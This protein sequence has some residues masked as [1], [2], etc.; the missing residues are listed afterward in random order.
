[1]VP[2]GIAMHARAGMLPKLCSPRVRTQHRWSTQSTLARYATLMRQA[3][4]MSSWLHRPLPKTT[5]LGVTYV[6]HRLRRTEMPS[7]VQSRQLERISML[8]SIYTFAHQKPPAHP[9]WH[10]KPF[11]RLTTIL[12]SPPS[13]LITYDRPPLCIWLL[14]KSTP[15]LG[16]LSVLETGS[17][18]AGPLSGMNKPNLPIPWGKTAVFR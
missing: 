14:D 8:T 3:K 10:S 6:T 11:C 1:M 2:R 18:A 16:D 7:S 17:G 5:L 15:L 4:G 9:C 12:L 13:C